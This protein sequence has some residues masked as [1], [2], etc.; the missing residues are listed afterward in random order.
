MLMQAIT[1]SP[2]LTVGEQFKKYNKPAGYGSREGA[3]AAAAGL[4]LLKE[5]RGMP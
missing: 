1:F 4:P 5:S 3:A 2:I